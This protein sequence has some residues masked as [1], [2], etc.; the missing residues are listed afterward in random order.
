MNRKNDSNEVR[1]HR[2]KEVISKERIKDKAKIN[3]YKQK[4]EK[5]RKYIWQTQMMWK[6]YNQGK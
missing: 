1:K 3:E 4:G 5:A 2:V 6:L